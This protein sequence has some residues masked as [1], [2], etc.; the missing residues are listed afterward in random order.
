VC[1]GP[2]LALSTASGPVARPV[3]I[4]TV[5]NDLSIMQNHGIELTV[6][7]LTYFWNA[8]SRA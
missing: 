2:Q 7:L 4:R 8:F 1:S 5:E 6:Q 3:K